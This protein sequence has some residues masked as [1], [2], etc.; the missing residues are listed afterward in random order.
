MIKHVSRTDP[1]AWRSN[2]GR[3]AHVVELLLFLLIY[4]AAVA[5]VLTPSGHFVRPL[6]PAPSATAVER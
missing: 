5:V 4:F 3:P 2:A 6:V 1:G